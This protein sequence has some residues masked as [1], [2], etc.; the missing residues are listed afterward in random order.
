MSSASAQDQGRVSAYSE[1][2]FADNYPPGMEHH[3]WIRSRN[4]ILA[5][6]LAGLEGETI[7]DVGCG[8]GLTVAFLRAKGFDCWGCELGRPAVLNGLE[9]FVTIGIDARQLDRHLRDRVGAILLL[10]VMEHLA[11]PRTFLLELLPSFPNLRNVVV[12]VPARRELWSVWDERYGHYRRYDRRSLDATL[13]EAGLAVQR[14]SYF[15]RSLY[16]VMLVAAKLGR[17][18]SKVNAPRPV[19]LHRLAAHWFALEAELPW[20][21]SLVGTS[22]L[23]FCEVTP[24]AT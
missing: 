9:D 19:W 2:Q 12:T 18:A 22:L 24:G 3:W 15:F 11:D 21:A 14:I 13:T 6:A 5:R 16:P 17:R 7:L 23:A 8:R 1:D 4:Q 10:D 20:S